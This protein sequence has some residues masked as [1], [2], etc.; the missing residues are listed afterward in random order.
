M[1]QIIADTTCSLPQ[2]MTRALRIPMLPQIIIFGDESYRDDTEMDTATF[3]RR[4]HSSPVLPKTAAPPPAL[5]EPIYQRILERGDTIVV[6]TPSADLSGTYRSAM[7]AALNFPGAP[8]HVVDMRMIAGM[9]GA[10][11]ILGV[12]WGKAGMAVPELLS[13]LTGLH[14]LQRT[15][16]LVDTLEFL[17]RGGRIGGARR[18]LGEMLQVKP[19]LSLQDGRVTA[20]EQ[21]RTKLKALKRLQEIVIRECPGGDDSFLCV[22]HAEAKQPAEE[23]SS[24]LRAAFGMKAIPI[25]ELPPA[26]GVHA[27]P[28]VLAVGFFTKLVH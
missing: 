24:S 13:R 11:V 12:R 28:G 14:S 19:I 5:Y 21:P 20:Y 27:G 22:M 17:H 23:L 7:T 15:Y 10:A 9:L 26:I 16:F 3:L 4:L 6:V 8:I 18:L 1:I 2:E 25:Y